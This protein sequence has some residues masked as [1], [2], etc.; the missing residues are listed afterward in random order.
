MVFCV[1]IGLFLMIVML[2]QNE[3]LSSALLWMRVWELLCWIEVLCLF[4]FQ[5]TKCSVA[6]E[7]DVL[8]IYRQCMYILYILFYYLTCYGAIQSNG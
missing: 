4:L 5:F 3:S 7:V 8:E 1:K 2:E 6:D